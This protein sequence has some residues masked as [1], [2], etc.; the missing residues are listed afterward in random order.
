M[1]NYEDAK[2]IL[3]I[4]ES[5]LR[6]RTTEPVEKELW[7]S[8]FRHALTLKFHYEVRCEDCGKSGRWKEGLCPECEKIND[9]MQEAFS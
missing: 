4:A 2:I 1:S 8:V 5:N 7:K 9:E 6:L 3:D